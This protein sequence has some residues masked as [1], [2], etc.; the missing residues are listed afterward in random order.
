M[1]DTLALRRAAGGALRSVRRPGIR[2]SRLAVAPRD[3]SLRPALA[4]EAMLAAAGTL[5]DVQPA[6]SD[7]MLR[8]ALADWR[9]AVGSADPLLLPANANELLPLPMPSWCAFLLDADLLRLAGPVAVD[10]PRVTLPAWLLAVREAE[11]DAV[12]CF[13]V[14]F[15]GRFAP[16]G[17]SVRV[18]PA[19]S[20]PF[21]S[22][23][24]RGPVWV[25]AAAHR[26][27]APV[28]L[29]VGAPSS[30]RHPAPGAAGEAVATSATP[31]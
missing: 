13:P 2:L 14:L 20:P 30:P 23:Q 19:L 17:V 16:A 21:L 3:E 12:E 18:R 31:P 15:A 28:R 10:G 24:W 22:P 6:A 27:G 26:E 1:T 25:R 7:K 9:D 4:I 29:W 8:P 11:L 5:F